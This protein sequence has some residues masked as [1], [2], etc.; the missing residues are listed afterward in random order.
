V[1]VRI[2]LAD[3]HKMLRDGLRTLLEKQRDIQVI[4]EAD[5]GRAAVRLARE[6]S[7][8][9]IVMDIG[10]PDLNGVEATRQIMELDKGIRVIALSLQSDGP[11]VR[12]MFQA[13]AKAYLVKE[14]ASDELFTAIRAVM[15]GRTYVSQAITGTVVQQMVSP[16][17]T[18]DSALTAKEREVLQLMAEGKSSKDIAAALFVSSKT[19][20]THRQHIMS[21]LDLHNLADLTKYAIRMGLTTLGQ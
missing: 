11:V 14:A 17:P 21:K 18:S 1:S 3:D 6:L 9:V 20:D 12:R 15:A 16:D 4:G 19:V 10:M 7:P 8:D 2:L 13:G 5:D